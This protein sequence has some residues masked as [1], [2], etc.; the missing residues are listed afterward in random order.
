S[1]NKNWIVNAYDHTRL[2]LR[3]ELESLSKKK[4]F[5]VENIGIPEGHNE[6]ELWEIFK[7]IL[8]QLEE[9]DEIILDITHSFRYLPMLTFIII[10]YARIVKK[11]SLKAVY[12][13]AFEVLGYG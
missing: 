7:T 6:E 9:G 1:F 5:Q 4:G 8:D 12:Y 2:G 10:N 3:D 11:C 13:G